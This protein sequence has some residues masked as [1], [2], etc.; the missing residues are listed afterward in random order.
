MHL[1]SSSYLSFINQI[2]NLLNSAQTVKDNLKSLKKAFFTGK[3]QDIKWRKRQLNQIKLAF[4]ENEKEM[5]EALAKDLGRE[6]FSSFFM[7]I[8]SPIQKAHD[9]LENIETYA[10]P[11]KRDTP[12]SIAPAK[13]R[14][15][16]QPLGAVCIMSAWNFPF[17]TLFLPIISA[18]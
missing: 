13:S 12:L 8:C 3:T 6:E 2:P 5:A 17:I 14:V 7:E 4:E 1:F 15:V 10:L 9:D 16:Y 11:S 18:V